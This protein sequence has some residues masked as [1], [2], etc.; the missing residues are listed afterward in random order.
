MTN[1]E[2]VY[3]EL[4]KRSLAMDG[5]TEYGIT[6][7][8][9]AERLGL[10]RNTVSHLL[11]QLNKEEVVLKV[12]TR[13]VYFIDKETYEKRK[14]ELKLAAKYFSE[15][16]VNYNEGDG[17]DV[18]KVLIGFD[19][20]LRYVVEQCKSA[21][22]YPPNGLPLLLV[23][24]SGVGK[25]FLAHL[26]FH[27]AKSMEVIKEAAPFIL[28]NCAEYA[29]NPELLSATL[30]GHCKGAY[31]GA[32]KE[33]MGLIEE[34]D[35]GFLFMDEIHRLPPAGQEKLFLFLD[36]GLFRR[37]GEAGKGRSANVRMMF[38]TTEDPENSFLQTFL[39][40]IPLVVRIPTFQER[41]LKEKLELIYSF[42][43][44]ESVTI[45]RDIV[46]SNQVIDI[47]LKSKVNGNI[48]KLSN[49]IKLSCANAFN[50][51]K[52]KRSPSVRIQINNLPKE[53]INHY[54]GI[55]LNPIKFNDMLLSCSEKNE[56]SYVANE[57][58][59]AAAL[60]MSLINLIKKFQKCEM[61]L[62]QFSN[63]SLILLNELIDDIIFN[64]MDKN[65]NS[66]IFNS[67][68]KIVENTLLY[69]QA[70]YGIKHYGN[71]VQIVTYLLNY[72]I[73]YSYE[74]D[75]TTI[76][77]CID[78]VSRLYSKEYKIAYHLMEAVELN[79]NI[80]LNKIVI[81]YLVLYVRSIN[82]EVSLDHI[83]AVIIAH[84]YSTASSIASLANRML[85][86]YIFEAFDMPFELS[87]AEI[88]KKL[89]SY[90]K[91]ID[92]SK[93][94]IILID[95]GSLETVYKEIDEEFYGDIVII[96]NISTQLALDVGNRI[97]HSQPLK[98][99]A[100]EVVERNFCRYSY[101]PSKKR[102]KDA[103][104][105][106]CF[107]GIGVAAK[108]KDLLNRCFVNEEV[109]VIAYDY[110]KLKEG[111]KDND[112][113]KQYNIKLIIGTDNPQIEG[114]PYI[115]LEDLIMKR[116]D[117]VLT[118]ALSDL[119][120][121]EIIE[122]INREVIKSFT[123]YNVVNFLTILN[124]DKILDQ[125]EQA[126]YTLEIG[127]GFKFPNNLKISLYIH[128]CCMIER[129]VIKE[130]I[131]KYK[132][133]EDLGPCNLEFQKRIR[134]AFHFIEQFYKIEI[135]NSEIK[136]IYD[137]IKGRVKEFKM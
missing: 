117:I 20:S 133:T 21:V 81:L 30:F 57:V 45:K 25:S 122:Q 71:S 59:K 83:Y 104:I 103:I 96:N 72:F 55:I 101:I 6:A 34:A 132:E 13:P 111:G 66:V 100:K 129:L 69:I 51:F 48:G 78:Y 16:L 112:V 105:T 82:R 47:L 135:P 7:M 10:Q 12:N 89:N 56:F 86:K 91:T 124:P 1:K 52:A 121:K 61:N 50:L 131:V 107:T 2:K 31:T 84:G 41:P 102:K 29:N 36:Q 74:N 97:V 80:A 40:R 24:N 14:T 127:L 44:K 32:D 65:S 64:E 98:E 123:L 35:G 33:R 130:P 120:D 93:G 76:D 88:G 60:T 73:E 85:E 75:E 11:N 113:F 19:S 126:L 128:I 43:K 15:N 110:D 118:N 119:V 68:E 46:V 22:S 23:G 26:V 42:Y 9:I 92:T 114:I 116:G 3:L 27:Y 106:T 70:N 109:K 77:E 63:Q 79:L 125:V 62:D 134:N 137:S 5:T 87:A 90:I 115:S 67:I 28:F 53:L 4:K 38:A 54:E 17:R 58:K 99:V 8:D 18:F 49:A 39:R 108:I 94:L 95:M 136:V 37:V